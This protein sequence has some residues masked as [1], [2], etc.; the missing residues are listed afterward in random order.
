M[1]AEIARFNPADVAGYDKF[2]KASEAIFKVGFEQLGHVPFDSW[3]D[4]AKVLPAML[5]LESVPAPS[6]NSPAST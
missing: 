5:K 2:L 1:R 3:T 4:M 6:T